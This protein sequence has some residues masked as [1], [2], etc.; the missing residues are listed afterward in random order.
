MA[1]FKPKIPS[2]LGLLDPGAAERAV[3]N[4]GNTAAV[5]M[6]KRI[7]QQLRGWKHQPSF[8]VKRS[9]FVWRIRTDDPVFLYQDEGTDGPYLIRPRRKRALYWR[10]ARHP[11]RSVRHPGL[12]AQ[13]FTGRAAQAGQN[14]FKAAL[15][16]EERAIQGRAR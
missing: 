2:R 9:Q 7:Q 14:D 4:A 8:T 3:I 10:G 13:D 1:V 16:A 6:T 11:V 15:E 5:Q 12:K